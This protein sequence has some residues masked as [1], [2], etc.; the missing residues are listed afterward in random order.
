MYFIRISAPPSAYDF[1]MA[2]WIL[3]FQYAFNRIDF[4]ELEKHVTVVTAL[5]MHFSILKDTLHLHYFALFPHSSLKIQP[6]VFHNYLNSSYS[7][8]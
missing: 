5:I 2:S 6:S 3:V 1:S 8:S 4:N 7:L